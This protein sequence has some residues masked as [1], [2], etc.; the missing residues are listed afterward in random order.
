MTTLHLHLADAKAEKDCLAYIGSLPGIFTSGRYLKQLPASTIMKEKILGTEIFALLVD[1][2]MDPTA[3]SSLLDVI[4][5]REAGGKKTIIITSTVN[6]LP[7]EIASFFMGKGTE[8]F[9]VD[10]LRVLNEFLAEPEKE[11]AE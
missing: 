5:N 7:K 6:P 10:D 11:N 8:C 3:C 2:E 9:S 4:Q 1:R